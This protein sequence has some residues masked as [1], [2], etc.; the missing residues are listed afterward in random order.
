M[1][2]LFNPNGLHDSRP[3]KLRGEKILSAFPNRAGNTLTIFFLY[4]LRNP[5]TLSSGRF[6]LHFSRTSTYYTNRTLNI[7]SRNIFPFEY[8]FRDIFFPLREKFFFLDVK[9]QIF[10]AS[11][12][13][14]PREFWS[15]GCIRYIINRYGISRNNLDTDRDKATRLQFCKCIPQVPAK[16]S[17][18]WKYVVNYSPKVIAGLFHQTRPKGQSNER[19]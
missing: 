4:G 17:F 3:V 16:H 13:Y 10:V 5:I 7:F 1:M 12:C 8:S 9:S 19:R 18:G 2:S 11:I 6:Y 14:R 15:R